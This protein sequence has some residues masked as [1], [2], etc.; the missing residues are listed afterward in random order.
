[1]ECGKAKSGVK[2][3]KI[4]TVKGKLGKAQELWL[5]ETKLEFRSH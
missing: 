5:Q 1:M 3:A 4:V 2:S